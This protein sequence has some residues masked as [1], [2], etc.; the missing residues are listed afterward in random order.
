MY[1]EIHHNAFVPRDFHPLRLRDF[2]T[3]GLEGFGLSVL[4]AGV[5]LGLASV[6]AGCSGV[7]PDTYG[8]TPA[9]VA[10]ANSRPGGFGGLTAA[11]PAVV[12]GA[13]RSAG[14]LNGLGAVLLGVGCFAL[15]QN[16][17]RNSLGF[18]LA[19]A[20]VSLLVAGFILPL[21]AGWVGLALFGGLVVWYWGRIRTPSPVAGEPVNASPSPGLFTRL[22]TLFT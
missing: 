9:A 22:K 3:A 12:A 7:S 11:A 18:G 10:L 19:L 16:G 15:S 20:G 17:V 13:V 6:V 4:L 5:L 1:E 21:Y 14:W 2:V 8:A